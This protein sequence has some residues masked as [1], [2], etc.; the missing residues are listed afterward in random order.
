MATA[1][2]M[3]WRRVGLEAGSPSEEAV[4]VAQVRDDGALELGGGCGGGEKAQ[5]QKQVKQ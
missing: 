4:A 3:D 1:W 2:R 5:N